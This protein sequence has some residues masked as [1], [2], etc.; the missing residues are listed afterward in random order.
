MCATCLLT[1]GFLGCQTSNRSEITPTRTLEKIKDRGSLICGVNGFAKGFS[2]IDTTKIDV[3]QMVRDQSGNFRLE[4]VT[5]SDIVGGFDVDICKAIAAA[6]FDDPRG[7]VEYVF[8]DASTRF[9]ALKNGEIDVL[10]RNTTWTLSRDVITGAEF[11]PVVYYDGQSIMVRKDSNIESLE[12]FDG[13]SIC[14]EIDT[15]SEINIKNEIKKLGLNTKVTTFQ[16]REEAFIAYENNECEGITTD[17]SQLAGSDALL[18]R[19]EQHSPLDIT[20]SK[21]PFAPAVRE[22]DLEWLQ[23]IRVVIY[24]LISAEELDINQSNLG[25]SLES[26][27]PQ[28]IR[29]LGLAQGDTIGKRLKLQPNFTQSI[30]KHVGNYGEIYDR[31]LGPTSPTPIDRGINNLWNVPSPEEG[32]LIYSPPF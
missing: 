21:E 18:Q 26:E 16:D 27:D 13:N 24:A 20:L 22:D 19:P 30:V 8:L 4:G 12:D 11:G 15:T 1:F 28:V 7:K 3:K 25:Q 29:F 31:H 32:G 6:I 23:V 10:S 9:S 14:V 5:P 2:R 17:K